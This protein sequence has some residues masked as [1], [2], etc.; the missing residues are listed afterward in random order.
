MPV[1]SSCY[2][3][4]GVFFHR[5]GDQDEAIGAYRRAIELDPDSVGAYKGLTNI[6]AVRGDRAGLDKLIDEVRQLTRRKP[7][8]PDA[9]SAL[10]D[11][12]LRKDDRDGARAAFRQAGE[13]LSPDDFEGRFNLGRHLKDERLFD[14]ALALLRH[15]EELATKRK[16]AD[17]QARAAGAVRETE[18]EQLLTAGRE[19]SGRREWGQA[20]RCYTRLLE[21]DPNQNSEVYFEHAAVLLFSG[22]R[23]G[24]RQGCARMVERCGKDKGFRAYLA[25]RACTLAPAGAAEAARA[26]PL[27][28][29]ELKDF[30]KAFWSLTEQAAL[31]YRAGRFDRALPL[32]EQSLKADKD[33]QPGNAVLNWLWLALTCQK[34]GQK[35]QARTWLK[36]ATKW[37]DQ[38]R[39]GLP[40]RA[41]QEL[42]LHLHNW[43]EAHVLRAEAEAALGER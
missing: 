43:L 15:C 28:E 6:L 18:Q 41:E 29:Q 22:D 24:Y 39:D 5:K 32:L 37:L 33:K 27:A 42:G 31:H 25:A 14:D 40:P 26:A 23:D 10:G 4:L 21:R 13:A 35:A 20:A 3:S 11:L 8:D 12:L 19:H 30:A 7:R 9:Y 2:Y 34:L 36:T 38:Y 16:L 1:L 17:L